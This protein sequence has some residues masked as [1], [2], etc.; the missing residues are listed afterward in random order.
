MNSEKVDCYTT[1]HQHTPSNIRWSTNNFLSTEYIHHHGST[2]GCFFRSPRSAYKTLVLGTRL[3]EILW[4]LSQSLCLK[5][6]SYRSVSGALGVR[7]CPFSTFPRRILFKR[8]QEKQKDQ[9]LQVDV[10]SH[11]Q[12]AESHTM[13]IRNSRAVQTACALSDSRMQ[14]NGAWWQVLQSQRGCCKCNTW[15]GDKKGG[16]CTSSQLKK[17]NKRESRRKRTR[18]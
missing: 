16:I 7:I 1:A 11:G 10:T 6:L 3:G 12:Q 14:T 8:P 15:P 18:C 13:G 17:I 2:N 4:C 5:G 9:L